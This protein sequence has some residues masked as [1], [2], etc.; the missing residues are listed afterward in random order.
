MMAWVYLLLAIGALAVAFK[1]AS[2]GLMAVCLLLALGLI[3]AWVMTLL[4]QRIDSR[5]RSE[6]AMI[7]PDELRRMREQAEAR[8]AAAAAGESPR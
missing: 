1:T 2:V 7:D 3:L 5:S 4:A 6:H 8:K